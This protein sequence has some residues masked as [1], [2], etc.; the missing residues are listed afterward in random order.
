MLHFVET[1][2]L[3]ANTE[4]RFMYRI[5]V[6][7]KYICHIVRKLVVLGTNIFFLNFGM[8]YSRLW[9]YRMVSK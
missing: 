7:I 9:S 8:V 2:Y 4:K 6:T 1:V 5:N 3:F